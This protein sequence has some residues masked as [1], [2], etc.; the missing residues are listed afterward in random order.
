MAIA[1][2]R[3][4]SR[5]VVVVVVVVGLSIVMS[6]TK[7]WGRQR[8]VWGSAIQFQSWL[9]KDFKHMSMLIFTCLHPC[10]SE[11]GSDHAQT[12]ISVKLGKI[13]DIEVLQN[14]GKNWSYLSICFA[15]TCTQVFLHTLFLSAKPISALNFVISCKRT[16]LWNPGKWV[17]F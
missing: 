6:T 14:Q 8:W 7:R 3:V 12:P 15:P 1:R 11:I 4:G 9:D 2:E 10:F 16:E 13:M 17:S 5:V